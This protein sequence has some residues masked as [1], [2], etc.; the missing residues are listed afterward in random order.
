MIM[1]ECDWWGFTGEKQGAEDL[2]T[3]YYKDALCKKPPNPEGPG[4]KFYRELAEGRNLKEAVGFNNGF[5][6]VLYA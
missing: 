5:Y 2:L 6:G 4:H 1:D 3:E